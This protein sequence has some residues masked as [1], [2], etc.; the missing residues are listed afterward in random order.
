MWLEDVEVTKDFIDVFQEITRMLPSRVMEF[1]IDLVCISN[2]TQASRGDK[3][4]T[5]R[6]P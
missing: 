6:A 2:Y 1:M 5:G 4:T 3:E